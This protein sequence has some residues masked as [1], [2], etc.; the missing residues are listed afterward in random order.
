VTPPAAE[1]AVPLEEPALDVAPAPVSLVPAAAAPAA[2]PAWGRRLARNLGWN[3]ISEFTA[4]G[5]SLWL[6]FACARVLGVAA[7]GRFSFALALAQYVWL[8]GDVVASSGYAARE[9]ARVRAH[10]RERARRIKG[11]ILLVRLAAGVALAL[12]LAAVALLAPVPREMR[13]ALLGAS[14]FFPAFAAFPD[15][16][17]RARED[18]RLLAF[19]NLAGALAI[20]GLTLGWLPRHPGAGVAVAIWGGSFLVSALVTLAALVPA[21]AFRWTGEVPG[22]GEQARRSAVFSAGSLAGMG[23]I[24][25][26]MLLVGVVSTA[27]DAGLFGAGYRLLL[28]VVNVFTVLWWPLIP[29]LVRSRPDAPEHRDALATMGGMVLLIGLPASL[30]FGIWPHE[31]LALAFGERYVA[32]AG[33]LRLAAV[34]LPLISASALMEQTSIATGRELARAHVNTAAL[35]SFLAVGTALLHGRGPIG[36]SEG[37]VVAYAVSVAGYVLVCRDVMPWR[38]MAKHAWRPVALNAGL[39]LAWLACHV[40][41]VPAI[42]AIAAAAVLYFL[43]AIAIG[44]L[45]W[46][47]PHRAR[48]AA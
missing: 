11:R 47:R 3:A 15:W 26:P 24:Q 43:G 35:V 2:A 7:F 34:M 37:L 17:L 8:A 48:R 41:R 9:V 30:L 16:A 27:Y 18:F 10:D 23:R 38:E 4:R 36:A 28:V 40:L 31:L 33:M 29:V 39:G 44:A 12:A 22:I 42:P 6:A 19:A 20:V 46:M 1:P 14:V 32:G 5:A 13:G 25:A 45:D 21:G